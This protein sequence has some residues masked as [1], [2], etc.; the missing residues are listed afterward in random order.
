MGTVTYDYRDLQ[1][2]ASVDDPEVG[3]YSVMQLMQEHR[4]R[5]VFSTSAGAIV[6]RHMPLRM[7]RII[8]AVRHQLYPRTME[9]EQEARDLAPYFE[10]VDPAA[11][12]AGAVQRLREIE[13]E[14]RVTDMSALGVIEAPLLANMDDYEIL[15]RQLTEDEQQT[16]AVAVRA[17]SAI[18]PPEHVDST[19]MTIAQRYGLVLMDEDMLRMLTVSQAAFLMDRINKENQEIM[20]LRSGRAGDEV[21]RVR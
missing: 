10:G 9:L 14:L 19:A 1:S 2:G 6:L 13:A 18:K 12:D 21:R 3:S 15:L 5:Y 8:D 11:Y 7:K 17:L 16:L 20:R 4:I